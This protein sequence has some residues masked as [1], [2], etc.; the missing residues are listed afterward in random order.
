MLFAQ[1]GHSIEMDSLSP[2]TSSLVALLKARR[3]LSFEQPQ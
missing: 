3:I 2:K 1:R